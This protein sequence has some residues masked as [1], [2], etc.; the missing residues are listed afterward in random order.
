MAARSLGLD[1]GPMS[2]FDADLVNAEFFPDGRLH[3][4]FLINLGYGEASKLY[5]RSPRFDF[6]EACQ[7]L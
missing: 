3:V 6:G 5:G 4:N 7:I 2:G 1:C